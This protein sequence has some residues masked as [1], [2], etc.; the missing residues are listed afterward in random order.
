[1]LSLREKLT[2]KRLLHRSSGKREKSS[3]MCSVCPTVLTIKVSTYFPPQ[4]CSRVHAALVHHKHL[5][6]AFLVDLGSTHGTFIGSV[7]LEANK[8]TPLPVDSNFHFGASTRNYII[9]ERPQS[10]TRP[11]MEEIEKAVGEQQASVQGV[12]KVSRP[13]PLKFFTA[14]V[15]PGK[16]ACHK[17]QGPCQ[18]FDTESNL[19]YNPFSVCLGIGQLDGL[20]VDV[21]HFPT[22]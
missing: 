3:S 22:F 16:C 8:P 9:R 19:S 7:R 2:A 6:R 11:I 5:K 12:P 10:G 1:M 21:L 4:S 17:M 13:P 15:F 20:L 18:L 14:V